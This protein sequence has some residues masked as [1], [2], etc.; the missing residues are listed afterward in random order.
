MVNTICGNREPDRE[1]LSFLN[2]LR[3]SLVCG[4]IIVDAPKQIARC[5]LEAARILGLPTGQT[6]EAAFAALPAPFQQIA[7]ETMSSSQPPVAR[8]VELTVSSRA[9][10]L[11]RVNGL[12]L[13]PD[14][15]H[16]A[17]LLVVND[18][19]AARHLEHHIRQLDRLANIGT[20]SAGMAH[21]IKNALVAGKTFIDLLLERHQDAELAE[22]VRREMGRIDAIVSRMLRFAGPGRPTFG[23]VGLHEVLERSLRLVQ[24]QLEGKLIVLSQAFQAAPDRVN[25]DDCQLQQAFVNLL[26]NALEAMG[27]SGTLTVTTESISPDA[28]L[29]QLRIVIQDNGAGIPPENMGRLFEPFFT[30]K[31]NGTGLGL[32]ITRRIIREHGG[33]LSVQ[34]QPGKGATFRI[35]LPALGRAS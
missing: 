7:L 23:D 9:P 34:S 16:S 33:D 31:P 3:G 6:P 15:K 8:E 29:A 22:V 28:G 27:Q 35:V 19:T 14:Q 2:V 13:H 32:A 20:L 21:E 10:A 1:G 26:L 17:V 24:P 4:S 18:L 11:L 5:S 12:S 25:G 30:T